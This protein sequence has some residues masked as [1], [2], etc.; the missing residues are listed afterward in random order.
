MSVTGTSSHQRGAEDRTDQDDKSASS[1]FLHGER[2]REFRSRPRCDLLAKLRPHVFLGGRDRT[3]A[4]FLSVEDS[5][6]FPA[7][8]R[9]LL[10]WR[11]LL[12][13]SWIH[14]RAFASSSGQPCP[15]Q[16]PNHL[17]SNSK[18]F[19]YHSRAF[20]LALGKLLK[21]STARRVPPHTG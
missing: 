13:L 14:S 2:V 8:T 18:Y 4:L 9:R 5:A 7:P 17:F 12:C 3:L 20:F 19:K 10:A 21:T 1:I 15:A 6:R 16:R 11:L